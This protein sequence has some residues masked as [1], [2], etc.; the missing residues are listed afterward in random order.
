[1]M[2]CRFCGT[3][4]FQF[5]ISG[6][7]G[8]EHCITQFSYP[9]LP[10]KKWIPSSLLEEI[11]LALQKKHSKIHFLS[12]RTRITRNLSHSVFPF[13]DSKE[14]EVKRMLVENGFLEFLHANENPDPI[15]RLYLG[16]ED[17][18]RF[19]ILETIDVMDDQIPKQKREFSK[20]FPKEVRSL[21]R[22]LYQKKNWAFSRGIGFLSSCPTNL[23]KGRRDSLLIGIES[24]VDPSFFSLFEKLSEFGIEFAPSTDHRRESLGNF[25]GLVVKIS[26][27]NAF[28]VQK[29]QF[30]KILG[31]RGSL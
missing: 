20:K 14:K 27:K 25:R 11:Q 7:F 30:Y 4:L 12:Y 26:W 6:K 16:S 22:F 28:A 1:M 24:G 19:E 3:T 29:R 21:L 15:Y 2:F 18:L 9:R 31:L 8:C 17:H 13:Y 10:I 5:R 23:G